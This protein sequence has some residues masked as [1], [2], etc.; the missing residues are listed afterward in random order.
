VAKLGVLVSGDGSNLQ[1]LIDATLAAS[2]AGEI[3]VVISNKPGVRALQR[4]EKA[5][6]PAV[7]VPHREFAS[8]E[9]FDTQVVETL[10][11]FDV[12]WVIL[13][14]F[15]RLITSVL[16]DAYPNRIVNLHPSLLPAFPGVDAG[17]QAFDYGCKVTGCTVHFVSAEMDSGPV[18]AQTPVNVLADDTLDSLMKR[19]HAA[20]HATLVHVVQALCDGRVQLEPGAGDARPRV[21]V[22]PA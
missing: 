19:I 20:E 15:M 13:A 21:R 10:Q 7:C 9:A 4:A 2:I 3:A 22:R 18:I 14:G 6:I 11:S 12:Q 5:G 16:L 8:R 1:A 17:K